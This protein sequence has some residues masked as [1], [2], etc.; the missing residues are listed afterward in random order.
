MQLNLT[1]GTLLTVSNHTNAT[2][3]DDIDQVPTIVLTFLAQVALTANFFT[4]VVPFNVTHDVVGD[5]FVYLVNNYHMYI[6][7]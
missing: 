4:A 7:Y 6:F 2:G 3:Y 5:T 1:S